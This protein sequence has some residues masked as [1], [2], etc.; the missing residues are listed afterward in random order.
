MDAPLPLNTCSTPAGDREFFP[1]PPWATRALLDE[2]SRRG[3]LVGSRAWEPAC[4][5][6]YMS[7]PLAEHFHRVR[8]TDLHDCRDVFPD[9]DEVLDFLLDWPS[10]SDRDPFDWII[11]NPPFKL[12]EE[13][14]EVAFRRARVGVALF[15][16][17]QWLEGKVRHRT[18]FSDPC[19]RPRLILQFAERVP[20]C[21]ERLDPDASTN[22]AYV[23]IVWLKPGAL[24][25][26]A[27]GP[28]EFG[29]IA[30]CRRTFERPSDYPPAPPSVCSEPTELL[31]LMGETSAASGTGAITAS[32]NKGLDQ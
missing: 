9:Q 6:G 22:Q 32:E 7:K 2:L 21:K 20:L 19:R 5:E 28:T 23:W 1:T 29:W 13:F 31:A 18:I 12:A 11:T 4:G 15:L 10:L 30:P 14:F 3:L 26:E 17:Q 25:H 8:S 27:S 24:E 16:K